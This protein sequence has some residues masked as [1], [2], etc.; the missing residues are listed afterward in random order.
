MAAAVTP[1]PLQTIAVRPAF[2]IPAPANPPIK[3]CEL[4]EGI[5]NHQVSRF[6]Q[7]APINA[8]KITAAST[9]S[10]ATMPVPTVCATWSPKNKNAMKLKNA[11]Q[12]TAYCGRSTRVET[13]VAMELA[14]SCSPFKKSNASATK[15]RATRAE[16]LSVTSISSRSSDAK[17]FR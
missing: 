3:A 6:Q 8:P 5:P 14:A 13:T 10:A 16:K 1:R 2:I 15:I 4:L 17:R 7:I 11:A 12:I 9:T